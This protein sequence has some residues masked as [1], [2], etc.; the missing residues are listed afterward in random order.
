MLTVLGLGPQAARYIL[1]DSKPVAARLAPVA[2][3]DLLPEDDRPDR[4][5]A[6]CTREAQKE[7]WPLL[8]KE[9]GERCELKP[10]EIPGGTEQS[11]IDAFLR[12]VTEAF[13]KTGDVPRGFYRRDG[14]GAVPE[15]LDLTV[16]VTHGYR[17]FSFLTYVS[18]LYLA[19]LRRIR[20][21]GAYYGL[22]N[23]DGPSPF[24]DL[25]PLLELPRW[26]HALEVLGETGSAM[27]L[28]KLIRDGSTCQL[29]K[30]IAEDLSGLSEAYLSGLPLELGRQTQ[31]AK[32]H[33]KPLKRLL[34]EL[35]LPLAKE[36]CEQF[37]ERIDPFALHEQVKKQGWKKKISL[38]EDELKRQ[39]R[40]ID[41]LMSYGHTATALGLMNEWT[42][43]W[44]IWR[45][46]PQADW[47]DYHETRSRAANL[48]SSIQTLRDVTYLPDILTDEQRQLG[49]FWQTLKELRNGYNHHG[50]RPQ[51][52]VDDS[53]VT[54][55]INCIREYWDST[56]KKLPDFS[57]SLGDSPGGRVL[58][59]PIGRRPGV[60]FSA[61]KAIQSN[62]NRE[63]T[64]C[65][66]IC[67]HETEGYIQEAL[68]RAGYEGEIESLLLEDAFGG[69]REEIDRVANM[70]TKHLVGTDEVAVNVTGGTTLMGLTV[71]EIA[72]RARRL[73]R[74]TRRFGLIDRR[75]PDLQDT[76]PYRVG[77]PFWIDAAEDGQC[78]R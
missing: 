9:L 24:L 36:L 37:N 70:A 57:L 10:I 15:N 62:D 55:Q 67:S 63:L 75:R 73:A 49:Q 60:L 21:R 29:V 45:Q 77:E 34:E 76:D 59:S 4:I 23:R 61:V 25:R 54:G 32:Q 58:V 8:E 44:A 35:G 65:L 74:P 1:Q 42:V 69:G 2:L 47:L 41:N 71:E 46:W 16:D 48:L 5:L 17:H 33:K 19:A 12:A 31:K 68:D 13:S 6:L 3:F 40:V 27:P 64:K 78:R 53:K 7:S 22:L 38:S 56:L 11:D 52:L 28:S 30:R 50:M 20:V 66:V 14:V 18:V 51:P 39:A 72:S 43:S 26:V